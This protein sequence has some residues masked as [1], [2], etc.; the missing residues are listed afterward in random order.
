MGYPKDLISLM[1]FCAYRERSPLEVLKKAKSIKAREED[2]PGFFSVLQDEGF[3]NEERYAMAYASDAFR[4]KYWGPEK[5][6]YK[7]KGEQIAEHL[8]EQALSQFSQEEYLSLCKTLL[9][10][11]IQQKSGKSKNLREKAA[12]YLMGRGFQPDMVY[13]TLRTVKIPQEEG[14]G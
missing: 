4:L 9:L 11:W 3:L 12:R 10:K 6:R 14:E 7:L 5:I 2:L 1:R 13:D 8:C